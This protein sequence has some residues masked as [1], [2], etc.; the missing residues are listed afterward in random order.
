[1][2]KHL[3]PQTPFRAK[4]NYSNIGYQAAADVASAVSGLSWE[5]L[6]TRRVLQPLGMECTIAN[7][8]EV[9]N[10]KNYASPHD[11]IDGVQRVVPREISRK[12]TAAAGGLMAAAAVHSRS[13][14][15][16]RGRE[17]P[18]NEGSLFIV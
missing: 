11:A 10:R 2:F 3:E 15:I 8:D 17:L 5:D 16:R 9:P 4:W 6:V 13:R 7:F 14:R 18:V 12:T 1:M